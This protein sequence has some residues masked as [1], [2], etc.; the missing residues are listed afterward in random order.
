M[1]AQDDGLYNSSTMS[2]KHQP[3]G[4]IIAPIAGACVFPSSFKLASKVC[5]GETPHRG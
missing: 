5:E 3:L 4:A 1:I 2:D